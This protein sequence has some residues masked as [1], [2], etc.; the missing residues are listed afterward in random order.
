[1]VS[2]NL[3]IVRN[4]NRVE[5]TSE[6]KSL[7][8]YEVKGPVGGTR[9]YLIMDSRDRIVSHRFTSD[10]ANHLAYG[11][12]MGEIGGLRPNN[13]SDS[14]RVLD[15]TGLGADTWSDFFSASR[16]HLV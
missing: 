8:S 2:I 13:P 7:A 6:G 9:V 10:S 14:Y 16:G 12:L 3:E 15:R 11:L 1:M 5:A 4:D